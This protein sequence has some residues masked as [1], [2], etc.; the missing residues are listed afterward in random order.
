[1]SVSQ[2]YDVAI[3]CAE[4]RRSRST[5]QPCSTKASVTQ[6]TCLANSDRQRLVVAELFV[7]G[8]KADRLQ[9]A[10][11]ARSI[12]CSGRSDRLSGHLARQ[13]G[14]ICGGY[15]LGGGTGP[16]DSA[17]ERRWHSQAE[18]IF[19]VQSCPANG[20][21]RLRVPH[22]PDQERAAVTMISTR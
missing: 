16:F 4:P 22:G 11:F 9:T 19:A 5:I 13:N 6:H 17:I 12:C 20:P 7:C 10:N 1:M 15:A 2:N 18:E 3:D 21:F 8:Q 14:S